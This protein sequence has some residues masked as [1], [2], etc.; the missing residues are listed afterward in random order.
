MRNAHKYQNATETVYDG[1]SAANYPMTSFL[2]N[3]SSSNFFN[4]DYFGGHF[5][6]VSDFNL[7][8]NYTLSN[9]SQYVDGYKT[10]AASDPMQFSTIERITAGYLM[11]TMEFG[12]L[13]VVAGV[14]FEGT[15]LNALGYNV[16]PYPG[17]SPNCP[18]ST[19]CG[20]PVPVRTSP[21]YISPL[22]SVSLRYSLTPESG[23]GFVYGRGISRPDVYQ[24]VPYVTEDDSTSP[25]TI[26]I[27]NPNL[28]PEHANN[29]D[30]LYE[31][32]LRPVG[33]IQAGFFYKQLSD[34]LI[35]TSYTAASGIY[36]G[37]LVSQWINA[38]NADL[39]GFEVSYQQRM[40]WLPGP[41]SALGMLANYSWTASKINSI[42][43]R[44]D[45]PALQR[46]TPNTWNISPTYDRGRL[47]VRVGLSYNGPSIYQYEYQKASDP[48]GL[49]P[50]GPSGDVYTLPHTQLDA[51]ASIRM[52]Q[53]FTGVIYGLNLTDEVFGY[54][55]GS[56]IFVKQREHYKPTYAAGLRYSLNRER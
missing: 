20:V 37:D 56:P 2:N 8:Q 52:G 16:T 27:G 54:Y 41:L 10:A 11:N 6:P 49:G 7:L 19:G 35:S 45:S 4:N 17:G 31:R 38:S 51:Q 43:G 30:L 26:A 15:Q 55:T 50:T 36:Q 33:L 46:Q 13:H 5:G 9:L 34:A 25:P 3:F 14:R 29:Y 12:N 40:S 22:P 23:L 21:T 18:T 24:L 32:Y 42:P 47:S 44:T 48:S 28:K 53:G 1:W 39:Y